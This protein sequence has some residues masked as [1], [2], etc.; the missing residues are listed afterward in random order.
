M[1]GPDFPSTLALRPF[2][3]PHSSTLTHLAWLS[4][5]PH[6]PGKLYI[7]LLSLDIFLTTWPNLLGIFHTFSITSDDNVAKLSAT[8]QGAPASSFQKHF[9]QI[10]F[11][12][13]LATFWEASRFLLTVSSGHLRISLT[14]SSKFFQ[15][16]PPAR[17]QSH[18]HILKFCYDS[19]LDLDTKICNSYLLLHKKLFWN[20]AT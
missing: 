11:K 20:L 7:F 12:L 4:S 17:S 1:S 6:A 15:F 14:L 2:P 3:L 16:L 19:T 18:S 8:T 10:S 13:S 5:H 9:P